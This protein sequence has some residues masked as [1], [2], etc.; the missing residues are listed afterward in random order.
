MRRLV[1]GIAVLAILVAVVCAY[2]LTVIPIKQRIPML[3]IV[4]GTSKMIDVSSGNFKNGGVL[5]IR[6]TLMGD[7]VS[8]QLS[9]SNVPKGAKSLMVVM[10]DPDA[11][12]GIFIHWLIY[13]IPVNLTGLPE[14]IPKRAVVEGF[15]VQALNDFNRV[16]YNGPYPPSG[17][18]HR[19]VFMVI[20]LD[21]PKLD[22]PAGSS[23]WSVLKA[24]EGHVLAYGYTYALFKR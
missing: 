4:E 3:E 21:V 15:G 6:Y 20:A 8:P 22:V 17:E 1:I 11:P 23:A 12:K 2:A 10:Y 16:G 9:W 13:N 19:Y 5:P 24:A 7:D 18:T 14:N